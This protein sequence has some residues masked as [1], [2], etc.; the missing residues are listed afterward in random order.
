MLP[1][2]V[3]CSKVHQFY[4][5]A[6]ESC[7]LDGTCVAAFFACA[8]DDVT[9]EEFGRRYDSSAGALAGVC[10]GEEEAA[11]VEPACGYE[12]CGDLETECLE[13]D[14]ACLPGD[15][16]SDAPSITTGSVEFDLSAARDDFTPTCG[17]SFGR[18]AYFEFTVTAR[19][20]VYLDTWGSDFRAV[21]TVRRGSCPTDGEMLGCSVAPCADDLTLASFARTLDPG[22]YC[23]I[24]DQ[25]SYADAI[26]GGFHV[27]L[28]L[29]RGPATATVLSA[30]MT[31]GDTCAAT[32]V[33]ASS[34]AAAGGK[35]VVY[36]LLA[37]PGPQPIR[38]DTCATSGFPA[39]LS[40]REK[41]FA[42][43]EDF[44]CAPGCNGTT[45]LEGSLPGP[46]IFWLS[47]DGPDAATCGS[48]ELHL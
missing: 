41:D 42:T 6:D 12:I 47:V 18:D 11:G 2:A 1:A 13:V 38:A 26:L 8:N 10:L 33:T 44:L 21:L 36:A 35:D 16:A 46:G 34:C 15:Q 37:C 28:R 14:P 43:T 23:A 39:V 19:E 9:C 24:V 7:G 5:E 20:T 25:L 3:A 4:C 48:F 17:E 32:D 27:K 29:F 40:V 30:N 22:T 45:G 31:S